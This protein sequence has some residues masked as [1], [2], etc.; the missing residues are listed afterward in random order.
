M[1]IPKDVYLAY[2]FS[3]TADTKQIHHGEIHTT[4]IIT[5]STGN[6]I[7]QQLNP[8]L[9]NHLLSS[10]NDISIGLERC[11]WEIP[12]YICASNATPCY[13]SPSGDCWRLQSY[14]KSDAH[15]PLH[16]TATWLSIGAALAS[17]H[18]DLRTLT[19]TKGTPIEHFH[20]THYYMQRLRN[21]CPTLPAKSQVIAKYVIG[22]YDT[23]ETMPSAEQQ[24]THGDPKMSNIL[25]RDGLPYTFIDWDTAMYANPWC[26]IGDAIR[27]VADELLSINVTPEP[28]IQAFCK[29]Y[30]ETYS[31]GR[32]YDT[33]CSTALL[34]AEHISLELTARY[35]CD[36]TDDAYFAY[37][38]TRYASRK[39]SNAARANE[40]LNVYKIISDMR[41]D[42]E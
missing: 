20:D 27:S 22:S 41:R 32:V 18:I 29:G 34:A 1:I 26:D 30:H 8:T 13:T 12:R 33:F 6:Y 15:A 2:G 23:C 21:Y 3:D 10:T 16:S 9:A 40:S 24:I 19:H 37:D 14:I 25:F 4:F 31:Y 11:G 36:I 7:L 39:Q 35:L 42:Y 5:D 17:I 38:T 28:Y